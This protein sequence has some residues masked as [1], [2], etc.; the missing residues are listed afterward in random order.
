MPNYAGFSKDDGSP[1][2]ISPSQVIRLEPHGT[3]RG[4]EQTYIFLTNGVIVV[5]GHI[6][7]VQ[8]K[9]QI[10]WNYAPS[11]SPFDQIFKT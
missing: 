6:D 8:D 9:L 4:G 5:Q 11:P 2:R 3:T 1:V 7:E 10:A